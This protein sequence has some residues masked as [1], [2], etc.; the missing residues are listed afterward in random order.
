MG[1]ENPEAWVSNGWQIALGRA[2]NPAERAKA[3]AILDAP[4]GRAL[5][6]FCL[7]LFN[8]NEVVYVD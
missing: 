8:L 4:D 7:M 2:P 3:L 5:T 6:D 1:G